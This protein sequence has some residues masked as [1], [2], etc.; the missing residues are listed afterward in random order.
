[1]TKVEFLGLIIEPDH[2]A[3]DETKLSGIKDWPTPT[4]VSKTKGFLGFC[5]FYRKFI[6]HYADIV[7]PLNDLT[8]KSINWEWTDERDNAFK[9]LKRMFLEAPV[10]LMPDNSKPFEIESDASKFASGAVLRQQDVNGDMHPCGYLFQ[11]F[12]KAQRN[13]QIYDRELLGIIRALDAWR[14]YLLGSGHTTTVKSDHRNLMYYKTPQ[15]LTPRQARWHLTLSQYDMKLV[16]T[17]G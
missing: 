13:Y 14:H 7:K 10:L 2:I 11:S 1:M 17:P 12:D 5:N 15:K 16:H 4:D 6:D 3:M 8:Q 9:T